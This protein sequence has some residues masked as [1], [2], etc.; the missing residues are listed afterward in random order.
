M[1][2][3]VV[4]VVQAVPVVPMVQVIRLV[5]LVKVVRWSGSKS[6]AVICLTRIRKKEFGVILL[7]LYMNS[8]TMVLASLGVSFG[9]AA[10]WAIWHINTLPADCLSA[11]KLQH[12]MTCESHVYSLLVHG[13][14]DNVLQGVSSCWL[15]ETI[16]GGHVSISVAKNPWTMAHYSGH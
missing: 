2:V 5:R 3:G 15:L 12:C 1:M 4:Q 16:R 10:P 9:Q 8:V 6:R 7:C 13:G 14:H 11:D